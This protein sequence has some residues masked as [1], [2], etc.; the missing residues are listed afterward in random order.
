MVSVILFVLVRFFL[1]HFSVN[2]D[3]FS[4]LER[5]LVDRFC[6]YNNIKISDCDYFCEICTHGAVLHL[7]WDFEFT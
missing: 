6:K 3:M 7:C 4:Y 5:S 2:G 1:K